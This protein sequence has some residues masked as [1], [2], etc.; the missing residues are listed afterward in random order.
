[1]NWQVKCRSRNA[2]YVT[3]LGT[4]YK[5]WPQTVRIGQNSLLLIKAYRAV[6][7]WLIIGQGHG[8][9]DG[10]IILV[11][12][13]KQRVTYIFLLTITDK[14]ADLHQTIVDP[15]SSFFLCQKF[16][17]LNREKQ[18]NQILPQEKTDLNLKNRIFFVLTKETGDLF[19][20]NRKK[21]CL[22]TNFFLSRNIF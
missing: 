7:A 6:I 9:K 5:Q 13:W 15:S 12:A 10:I 18:N 21:H 17:S 22:S 14:A 20:L 4:S 1:M 19:I 16:F 8:W 11:L 2:Q 3:K